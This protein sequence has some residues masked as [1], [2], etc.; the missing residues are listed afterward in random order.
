MSI[1]EVITT[2]RRHPRREPTFSSSWPWSISSGETENLS[3]GFGNQSDTQTAYRCRALYQH[4]QLGDLM[5]AL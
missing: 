5:K 4:A 3:Q 2:Q 1:F